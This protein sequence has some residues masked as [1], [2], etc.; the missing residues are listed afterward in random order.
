MVGEKQKQTLKHKVGH[1]KTQRQIQTH[2]DRHSVTQA[3]R[4]RNK[5]TPMKYKV[6]DTNTK[7]QKHKSTKTDTETCKQPL[8]H[9]GTLGKSKKF[10]HKNTKSDTQTH[11]KIRVRHAKTQRQT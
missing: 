4:E 6:R 7:G 8:R 10:T 1:T 5:K 9:T 2:A 3:R 11:K